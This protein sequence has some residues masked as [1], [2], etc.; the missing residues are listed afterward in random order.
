MERRLVA[1][2]DDVATGSHRAH[3]HES[4]VSWTVSGRFLRCYRV[5]SAVEHVTFAQFGSEAVV[6]LCIFGVDTLAI[7][8]CTGESFIVALPFG[9][10]RVCALQRGLLVQRAA[11]TSFAGSL[12]TLFSLLGP[13]SEFKMLGI[14][15]AT[16]LDRTSR[17][18]L[19]SPTPARIDGAVPVFNDPNVVLLC[20]ASSRC[21]SA[22]Y[23]L[24]WD[25]NVRRHIVYQCLIAEQPDALADSDALSQLSSISQLSA[26]RPRMSRQPSLSVRRTSVVPQLGGSRRK[27]GFTSAVKNDR[28]SSMLGRVSFDSPAPN[29][30]AD[31]FREQRQMRAEVVLQLCWSERRQR[32]EQCS[33]AQLCVVQ[34]STGA[35][36]VCVLVGGTVVTLD[37]AFDEVMRCPAVSMAH[38]RA[39]RPE[40]DDLLLVDA[41]G[42]LLL[43]LGGCAKPLCLNH[44]A[45]GDISRIVYTAGDSAALET[46]G[47]PTIAL[48]STQVRISRLAR[49]LIDS[50][51]FVISRS[52]ITLLW[53]SVVASLLYADTAHDEM[54]RLSSLL[55]YGSDQ[56]EPAT[57]L[58]ARVKAELRDRAPAVLFAFMLVYEDTALHRYE[59]PD[60][61]AKLGHLLLQFAATNGQT[62][63]HQALLRIGLVPPA[64]SETTEAPATR[65]RAVDRD[66][67]IVPSLAKW[68]LSILDADAQPQSFPTLEH[69]GNL[70]GITDAEP[71]FGARD[72][73]KLLDVTA[74][75]LWQLALGRDPALVLR[76]LA[77]DKAPMLL[78]RQITIDMRW[79]LCSV[80]ETMQQK[81]VSSWPTSILTLLG[82]HDMISNTN[83]T[84][85]CD[86]NIALRR[87]DVLANNG[88]GLTEPKS[89]V[90]I[91]DKVLD[92]HAERKRTWTQSPRA[93]EFS[94]LVFNRDLRLE[95]AERLLDLSAPTYT[96]TALDGADTADD[97]DRTKSQYLGLLARRVLALPLGQSLLRYSSRQLNPQDALP[98]DLPVVAAQFRGNK[99]ES[100]WTSDTDVSWPLFHSGVAAALSVE[101]DQ[102]RRE[103]PS[104]VLLNWPTEPADS[105]QDD[106]NAMKEFDA[107]L[108]SHAG[109][110]LGVGLL[111][112]DLETSDKYDTSEQRRN[113]SGPLSNMPPWQTFKYLSKRHGLTSIALLLGCA[114]AHRG[115]MNSSV[116]K[117]LSL[118]IPNLLPPGSSELMLLSYGT[119]A[120]AMLGLGLLFM[121]SQNRRMVEVMLHE[122]ESAEEVRSGSRLDG[123]DPAEST[124]ECYSLASG[125]SL[126]LVVLG[127]GLSTKTL[128]DL[129]LL[130]TLSSVINGGRSGAAPASRIAKDG[131]E[132]EA[133]ASLNISSSGLSNVGAVAAIGLAFLGTNYSPA[134][135]RLAAPSPLQQLRTADPFML[136]WKTLMQLLI[137]LDHI[138][139]TSAWI[140]STVPQACV[141]SAAN[142]LAPDLYRIRIHVVAAACF[143]LALKFAGTEDPQAHSII[144]EFFDELELAAN[145]PALDYESSLTRAAA[146][147][148][149]DIVCV[150]AAL[151]HAGSGDIATMKRLRALHGVNA[152]RSY[153][154]HMASHMA[155]GILFLGGGARFTISRSIQSIAL[156]LIALFPRFP[157]HYTDNCEHLQAWR[158][159]W[160]LCVVPRCLVVRDVSTGQMC[161]DAVVSLVDSANDK[162][163]TSIVPPV[164]FPEIDSVRTIRVSAPGYMVLSL[165]VSPGSHTR[166]LVSRRRVLYLQPQTSAPMQGVAALSQYTEWLTSTQTRVNV[167]CTQLMQPHPI[168]DVVDASAVHAIRRLRIC[169]LAMHSPFVARNS[170][171]DGWAEEAYLAWLKVRMSVVALARR[172]ET[173]RLLVRYWTGSQQPNTRTNAERAFYA[174]IALLYSVLDL[175]APS[176]AMKLTQQVPISQLI[177]H[178]LDT[179]FL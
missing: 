158:H 35:D 133:F 99:A 52:V 177:E 110:L 168:N 2:L 117:I 137:M 152:H 79:L 76:Q 15:R 11:E 150:S 154:N 29:Y 89:I 51:S 174:T 120:A 138:Q 156:L 78:L 100:T 121:Q 62:R 16:D 4:T 122:L 175:P 131:A 14:G 176:D 95:E 28:R 47:Q 74:N 173:R 57:T 112:R 80:I 111:P 72:S 149:L 162:Q 164:P 113:I 142:T 109:F 73:T 114:C 143:A 123:V 104:W 98:I 141:V 148:C 12:P 172:D 85:V 21:S 64:D 63:T 67:V 40:L 41:A 88:N 48:V 42:G 39:T 27:S 19:L 20:T 70:F 106:P 126:G 86:K 81:C 118:H 37:A 32:E 75:V 134:A 23:L 65:Q 119:Q 43:S 153:G 161:R 169:V 178:V 30:A 8:Y 108:A 171:V 18:L 26:S 9:V 55:L 165:D 116:S 155:L 135:Q 31:I 1:T 146:Q 36:V 60:R 82:R 92:Q 56:R 115:T 136:L 147:S 105:P 66:P 159:L 166:D 6:S 69:I 97:P 125:F 53:R 124:A 34:A 103:H 140:E 139:P 25:A 54:A 68:A 151:V 77:S 145:R 71:V 13:R 102:L 128:A 84:A 59:P 144:I 46:N 96:T 167:L 127:C 107:A 61:V 22:Q 130:D 83:E 10:R 45:T 132:L 91:C 24:C 160:A 44:R 87:L 163:A 49:S 38:V 7:Y 179:C 94:M 101:R 17:Q 33:D 3:I 5:D 93:R 170:C 50:L 157:Q 129:R 58:P 90:E